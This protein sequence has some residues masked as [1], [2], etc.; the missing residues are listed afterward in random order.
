[1]ASS[2][3]SFEKNSKQMYDK[4]LEGTPW[5]FRGSA[6]K[7][8]DKVIAEI[9]TSGVVTEQ[10]MYDVVHKATPKKFVQKSI[11]ILDAHSTWKK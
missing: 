6:Q 8:I 3:H 5:L 11:D 1:M 2:N 9:C 7:K 10:N 4:V